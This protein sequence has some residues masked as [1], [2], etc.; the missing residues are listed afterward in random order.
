MTQSKFDRNLTL[1]ALAAHVLRTGLNGASLRPMAAAAGT[2]D[3]M[4]IYHFGSKDKLIGELLGYL[5]NQMAHGLDALMPP[6]R[7]ESGAHL[8]QQI[9]RHIRSEMFRPYMRVWLDIVSAA[10]QG[11]LTHREAG[12]AITDQFL[13][14]IAQRHPDGADGA[15]I[16]LIFV[17]GAIVLDAAGRSDVVDAVLA[18]L[19]ARPAGAGGGAPLGPPPCNE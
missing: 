14:W 6:M 11:C 9:V 18:R 12:K 19:P 4:L 16:T 13:A 8:T 2:S 10:A 3:R 7:F 17:E 1:A 15:V 5:A